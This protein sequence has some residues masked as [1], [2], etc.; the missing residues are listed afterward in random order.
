MK[1]KNLKLKEILYLQ[2]FGDNKGKYENL[3]VEGHI[4]VDINFGHLDPVPAFASGKVSYVS[5]FGDVIIVDDKY[6]YTYSHLTDT[7]VEVGQFIE[8]GEIIGKLDSNGYSMLG[9]DWSH[10]HFGVRELGNETP[11]IWNFGNKV[12]N[13]NNGYD[14]YINPEGL[15]DRVIERVADAITKYENT[16]KEWNNPG[17]LRYSPFEN[18]NIGGF[19]RFLTYEDG[20]RALIYQLEI[21]SSGKSRY[22]SPEMNIYD[23]FSVYAPELDNN[24]PQRYAEFVKDYCGFR[25]NEKI[26][27]WILTELEWVKKYNGVHKTY[28]VADKLILIFNELWGK[29]FKN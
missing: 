19:S 17:A 29:I 28:W 24:N 21:A 26:K 1:F 8:C 27:D 10:L 25:G 2:G 3:G 18:S 22:Y 7:R 4:G 12:K 6:E 5:S 14:G 16:P 11:K 13:I 9:S 20:R 15:F 23:F